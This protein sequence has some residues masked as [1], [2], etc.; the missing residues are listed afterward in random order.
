MTTR[1]D[2]LKRIGGRCFDVALGVFL[3]AVLVLIWNSSRARAES[4]KEADPIN[5]RNAER[6]GG[7]SNIEALTAIQGTTC[8]IRCPGNITAVA[9]IN[10][11][12]V[13]VNFPAPLVGDCTGA[14][15]C[16]PQSGSCFPLGTTIVTCTAPGS[17]PATCSFSV[18]VFNVCL[19]DDS[20]P[21]IVFL[22]NTQTGEYIFCCGGTAFTG[23]AEVS[24][25][26]SVAAFADTTPDRRMRA[27]VDG[28]VFR[29]NASLQSPPGATICIIYDRDTRNNSCVCGRV[30]NGT[31]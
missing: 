17:P 6:K 19:Q 26:G 5:K 22:G 13:V 10:S 18:T 8:V 20:N 27:I 25:R 31:T 23:V 29:G 14:A 16:S 21:G 9:P 2:Q 28:A 12:C 3:I 15:V 24:R 11:P 1:H 4:T 7:R 30:V